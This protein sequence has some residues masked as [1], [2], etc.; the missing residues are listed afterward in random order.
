MRFAA[1]GVGLTGVW[2]LAAWWWWGPGGLPAVWVF[3][4]L[5]TAIQLAAV[6]WLKPAL[7]GPV[8]VLLKRWGAGMG[9]RFGG[10]VAFAVLVA[11][12]RERFPP[13]PSAL[14][15]VGVLVPLLF[16]EIRL[17]K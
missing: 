10:V 3:G 16:M 6:A 2:T 9:L 5:A 4:L 1:F 12:D 17:L 11:A 15:L 13:L 7:G 14:G 8:P